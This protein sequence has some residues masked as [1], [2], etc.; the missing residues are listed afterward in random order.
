MMVTFMPFYPATKLNRNKR[1]KLIVFLWI[2]II[3][4]SIFLALCEKGLSNCYSLLSHLHLK[5]VLILFLGHLRCI[6]DV[7][8]RKGQVQRVY[9]FFTGFLRLLYAS[10]A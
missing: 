7:A 3:P 8:G 9:D 1:P 10:T 4:V 5:V 2:R 6:A